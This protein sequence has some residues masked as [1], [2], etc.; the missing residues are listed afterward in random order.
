MNKTNRT[1]ESETVSVSALRLESTLKPTKK[2]ED[3]A[4][5]SKP[6]VDLFVSEELI[7]KIIDQVKAI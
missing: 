5:K 3:K 1:F 2:M 7:Q 4:Q 6:Q